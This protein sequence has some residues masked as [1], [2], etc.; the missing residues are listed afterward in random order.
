MNNSSNVVNCSQQEQALLYTPAA[1]TV[2]S[3]LYAVI[4]IVG[5]AGN[6]LVSVAVVRMR[7]RG[8]ISGATAGGGG[9][10]GGNSVTNVFILNLAVSDVVMCLLAVP[11]TPL[12]SFTGQWFFGEMLCHLFPMSQESKEQQ[13][14]MHAYT[15]MRRRNAIACSPYCHVL[16]VEY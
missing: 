6:V 9:G 8:N 4:F 11:L 12:Q 5:V 1:Q 13:L 2:F 7:H 10:C 14:D 3:L 15:N 16:T